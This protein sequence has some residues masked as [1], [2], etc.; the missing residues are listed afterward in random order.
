MADDEGLP[1]LIQELEGARRVL[2][3]EDHDLPER[4]VEIGGEL[5]SVVTWY[6]GRSSASVQVMGTQEE[7][8]TLQGW[9]R[10]A[11]ALLDGHAMAAYQA[12]RDLWLG[13]RLCQFEWGDLVRRGRIKKFH[14]T[15]DGTKDVRY[16]LVFQVEEADEAVIVTRAII[17]EPAPSGFS[18][19][20][21]LDALDAI[22]EAL[23][24]AAALSNAAQAVV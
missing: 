2:R 17:A 4:G 18:L 12:G 9:F 19:A 24:T 14:G 22:S 16:T 11:D 10:D 6:P 15:F 23:N 21:L 5:R 3:L 13:Q 7:P 8:I 20:A 1:V